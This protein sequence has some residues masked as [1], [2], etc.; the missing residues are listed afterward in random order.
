MPRKKKEVSLEVQAEEKLKKKITSPKAGKAP[1][2][3]KKP[4]EPKFT[5]TPVARE[6][7]T[8]FC[9]WSKKYKS[10]EDKNERTSYFFFVQRVFEK[11][12]EKYGEEYARFYIGYVVRNNLDAYSPNY[13]LR[14]NSLIKE[15][16]DKQQIGQ[17][18]IIVSEV[19]N[20]TRF[21]GSGK[22]TVDWDDSIKLE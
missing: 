18:E 5:Q 14:Q 12:V 1:K 7:A 6:I 22:V 20:E 3:P 9:D 4:K 15:E 17:R 2:E 8:M 10:I 13:F 16:Y 21:T 11:V 19:K